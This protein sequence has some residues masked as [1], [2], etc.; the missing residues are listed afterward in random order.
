MKF[1]VI[2]S[3]HGVRSPT[4]KPDQ[5]NRYSRAPWPDVERSSR[6]SDCAWRTSDDAFRRLRPRAAGRAGLACATAAAPMRRISE[7]LPTPT[8]ARAKPARRWPRAW[9]RAAR[10]KSA[11]SPRERPIR[12]FIRCSAG[13]GHPD[14]LLATAAISGRIGGDPQ[15]LAEAYRPQLEAL[16]EILRGCDPGAD[17]RMRQTRACNRIFDIPSSIAPGKGDHLVELRSPLGVAS[18]M[19]ENLLLEYTEG[20]DAANVGWGRVDIHK[21]REL[22][23]LHEANED[24]ARRTSYYR[25][26]SILQPAFSHSPVDGSKQSTGIPSRARSPGPATVFSFLSATI[27]TSPISAERWISLGSLTDAATTLRR[28][29]RWFLNFGRAA[30]RESIRCAPFIWRRPWTRCA[31]MRRSASRI[32]PTACRFLCPD[33]AGTIPPANG[34]RFS[35]SEGRD[36]CGFC[37]VSLAAPEVLL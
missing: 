19:A 35:S 9:R 4:G 10:S 14:K 2:V 23:Q 24:I 1:V 26:H 25:P 6:L 30:R 37:E 27:P 22:L 7:S 18:S 3:R 11:R 33:A 31:T 28:A 15:G 29:A 12:S 16:E 13:V 21:L 5:L 8:S 32:L 36:R 20:M 17:V 34:A